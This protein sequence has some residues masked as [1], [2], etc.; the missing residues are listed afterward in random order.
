MRSAVA[1][2]L[3]LIA[4]AALVAAPPAASSPGALPVEH[5]PH[6]PIAIHGNAGF[7]LPGSGVVGGSG[8]PDDPYVIE[9]WSIL[10]PPITHTG[11]GA[12]AQSGNGGGITLRGTSAHVVVR[13]V[14]ITD[15]TTGQC[16]GLCPF[17]PGIVVDGASNVTL[18]EV[19]F[20]NV[21]RTMRITGSQDVAVHHAAIG[22][23]GRPAGILMVTE[24][25]YVR[26]SQRVH[27]RDL[28][29]PWTSA[30]DAIHVH[31]V[32]DFRL[33][34][35]V[36]G[37]PEGVTTELILWDTPQ[38]LL[39]RNTFH[40]T[41]IWTDGQIE[42]YRYWEN[43]FFHTDLSLSVT[44]WPAPGA[45]DVCRN[46]FVGKPF[47]A[48]TPRDVTL[49]GN[50]F[51]TT[52]GPSVQLK[53]WDSGVGTPVGTLRMLDNLVTGAERFGIYG[54]AAE[55]TAHGNIL[56]E[57][58]DVGSLFEGVSGSLTGNWWASLD[59]PSGDGPGTGEPLDVRGPLAFDPWLTQRPAFD[60]PA[61]DA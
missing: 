15:A 31:R 5:L 13:D 25:V 57:T 49:R 45:L 24:G 59:G 38:V 2:A 54:I 51:A 6:P 58:T 36:L 7:A 55:V 61:C 19:A 3:L 35:S 18:E 12:D 23:D 16:Q 47:A 14:A 27:L 46:E 26:D 40:E 60:P 32:E 10:F 39:R 8:T 28:H 41:R 50:V 56:D 11:I 4:P 9:G 48:Q 44:G 52:Y 53:V 34:D 20:R 1:I 29:L 42:D 37:E 22:F 21:V 17:A 33:E 30:W 43:L